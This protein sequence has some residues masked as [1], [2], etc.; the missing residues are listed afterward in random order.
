MATAY[1]GRRGDNWVTEDAEIG[2]AFTWRYRP[3]GRSMLA[4][5]ASCTAGGIAG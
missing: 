5:V 2:L 4:N 1:L 3:T